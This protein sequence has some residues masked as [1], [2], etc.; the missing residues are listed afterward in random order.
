MKS[1]TN[2][3]LK[4]ARRRDNQINNKSRSLDFIAFAIVFGFLSL[5]MTYF[6]YTVTK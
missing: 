5:A 3:I 2:V 4:N 1:L 6:S